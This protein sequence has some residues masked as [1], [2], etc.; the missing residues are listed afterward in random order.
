MTVEVLALGVR[1]GGA[2]LFDDVTFTVD[3]GQCVVVSGRNGCG[4]STLLG[5]LYGTHCPSS[6]VVRVCGMTPD[7]R[8]LRFRRRVSTVLDDSALFDDLSP[9]Q[10][11]D[12]LLRSFP[13][14]AGDTD[15]WLFAAGLGE[16]AEVPAI[17]LSAGQRRR[18]L[19][20]AAVAR[21]HDVLLLDEPERALDTAGREWLTGL[22]T[23]DTRRGAAVVVA[24][25]HGP[26]AD[27]TGAVR[28]ELG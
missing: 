26:L 10:H 5:C 9:R 2:P 13:A 7:E 12:L 24:S 6:G 14:V 25:H 16:R 23:A 18:L 11:L 15:H 4:K 22:I 17:S 3:K 28:L 27:K 19:L 1:V 8:S 21:D 20:V